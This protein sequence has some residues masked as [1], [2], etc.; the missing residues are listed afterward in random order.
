MHDDPES[1]WNTQTPSTLRKPVI[2]IGLA[3]FALAV[4]GGVHAAGKA[5]GW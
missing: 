5:R 3:L 1:H 4:F 2:R